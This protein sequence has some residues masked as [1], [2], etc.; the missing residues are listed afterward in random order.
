MSKKTFEDLIE[1]YLLNIPKKSE[2]DS[3]CNIKVAAVQK[4]STVDKVPTVDLH[5]LTVQQAL[6]AVEQFITKSI[7][8]RQKKVHIIYGKGL[9]SKDKQPVLRQHV[10]D[11][12]N[13]DNRVVRLNP[14]EP[15]DG[16]WGAV[17][18]LLKLN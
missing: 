1:D 4:K 5:G 8:N 16:G 15:K 17:F 12:L 18:V 11:Y 3:L 2:D 13:N 6:I 14:A 9:H 10:Q 7:A